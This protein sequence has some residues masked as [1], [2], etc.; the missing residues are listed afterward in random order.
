LGSKIQ[1]QG[2][3]E[4]IDLRDRYGITQFFDEGRTEN[5]F[6]LAKTLGRE[7][8]IQVKGIVIEREAKKT[9]HQRNR[10]ISYRTNYTKCCFNTSFIED[11]TDG[12]ETFE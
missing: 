5:G 2:I 6:D 8:V 9:K 4:W 3:H 10:N 1:R 11:E 12:G 7:F